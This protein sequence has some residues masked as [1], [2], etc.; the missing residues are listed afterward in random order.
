MII[1]SC[2]VSGTIGCGN[3]SVPGNNGFTSNQGSASFPR[4]FAC[5]FIF[6]ISPSNRSTFF[7]S[8]AF[9]F[10]KSAFSSPRATP[11]KIPTTAQTQ[12][13][14]RDMLTSTIV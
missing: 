11:A 6:A 1:F 13:S 2:G 7:F 5:A 4:A 10:F 8:S 9:S 3:S 12:R 14:F